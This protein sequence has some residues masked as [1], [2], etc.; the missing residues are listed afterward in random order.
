V[1]IDVNGSQALRDVILA[2]QNSDAETPWLDAVLGEA[3]T[4]MERRVIAG[5]ATVA[6]SDQNIR[7]QS[8]AKGRRL[9]GGFDP[10]RDYAAVEFGAKHKKKSYMRKGHR[11]TRNTTAQFRGRRTQGYVFYPAARE[12]I[13]RLASL[14]VQTVVKT[15]ALIFEGRR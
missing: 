9:S 15:Y 8:A 3:D 13:P 2:L 4:T 5:T 7:I 10:K 11:V 1:R 6:V 12:M 14:W